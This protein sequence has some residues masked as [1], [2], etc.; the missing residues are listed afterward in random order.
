MKPLNHLE[1][2]DC[3]WVSWFTTTPVEMDEG[4]KETHFSDVLMFPAPR[5]PQEGVAQAYSQALAL[6]TFPLAS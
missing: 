5:S 3:P 6:Q 2:N 1:V 4:E